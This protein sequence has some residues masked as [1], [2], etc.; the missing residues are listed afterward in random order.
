VQVG[1]KNTS[2]HKPYGGGTV[3]SE[4]TS[5]PKCLY[6]SSLPTQQKLCPALD[7]YVVRIV[8]SGSCSGTSLKIPFLFYPA[9]ESTV[10]ESSTRELVLRLTKAERVV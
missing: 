7:W 4:V 1:L 9:T 6:Y 3:N 2:L 5:F 10:E 8:R